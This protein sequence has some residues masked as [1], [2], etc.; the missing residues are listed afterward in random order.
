VHVVSLSG[1]SQL[2]DC[3]DN[4]IHRSR[5][6]L[7]ILALASTA[8]L[9]LA[10]GWFAGSAR[11]DGDPASDV[12]ATQSLF[13]PQDAGIPLGQQS[14]LAGLLDAAAR[15]G[16]PIRVAI[17]ASR[18][19]LGSVT[20]LWRQPATYARFLGQEL[21]LV[22]GGPL[23]VVMPDG[24]G[25]Y[26]QAGRLSAA[27]SAF[28]G[29]RKPAGGTELGTDTLSAVER[30]AVASGFSV[31]IP[32]AA[33]TSTAGRGQDAI[34]VIALAIGAVL[35]AVA[36]IASLRVRPPQVRRGGTS[37]RH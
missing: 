20:E 17:I 26:R 23:L 34:P 2:T 12:L 18:T 21:S 19:D 33:A 10:S 24:Y 15:S 5:A 6:N 30:L 3:T 32:P 29:L 8:I 9:A 22:Y 1:S 27:Q 35:I 13:L 28:G 16:Y 11:A 7:L 25:F 31:P 37:S 14:Q 4:P 36:W